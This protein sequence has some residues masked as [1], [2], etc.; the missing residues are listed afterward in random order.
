MRLLYLVEAGPDDAWLVRWLHLTL[1]QGLTNSFKIR[2]IL[3]LLVQVC[4]LNV[5][6]ARRGVQDVL[7]TT[8][9]GLDNRASDRRSHGEAGWLLAPMDTPD[10]LI[11]VVSH[12]ENHLQLCLFFIHLLKPW[13]VQWRLVQLLGLPAQLAKCRQ[14]LILL[15][16]LLLKLYLQNVDSS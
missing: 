8:K 3:N 2:K 6:D 13:Q 12:L 15:P 1:T 4:Q 10:A 14:N 9:I 7:E 11:K 5:V 16:S